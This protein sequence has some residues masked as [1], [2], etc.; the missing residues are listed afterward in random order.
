MRSTGDTYSQIQVKGSLGKE[1]NKLQP[2]D[3]DQRF[4]SGLIY[5]RA[6]PRAVPPVEVP[7]SLQ[8]GEQ[9][10]RVLGARAVPRA[11]PRVE[12]PASPWVE[13]P[14]VVPVLCFLPAWR[15]GLERYLGWRLHS[16]LGGGST[17][18]WVEAPP[19][20]TGPAFFP[21]LATTRRWYRP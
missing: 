6:V 17:R 5:V 7:E 4:R 16:C 10:S 1:V 2:H 18:A 8:I 20:G 19:R 9:M 15:K 14:L 3:G 11:V 12:A 13:A 21:R